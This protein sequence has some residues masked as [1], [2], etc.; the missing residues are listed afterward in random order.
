MYI[1]KKWHIIAKHW[2][3]IASTAHTQICYW[4]KEK[5]YA[6]YLRTLSNNFFH[7][8]TTKRRRIRA[9]VHLNADGAEESLGS[10]A[11]KSPSKFYSSYP[12]CFPRFPSSPAVIL[13]TSISIT[14][15]IASELERNAG[16]GRKGK[17]LS[18]YIHPHCPQN[19]Y[20]C[21]PFLSA[22]RYAETC[23]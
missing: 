13:F 1:F 12:T 3:I 17:S 14:I 10:K 21:H 19:C 23:S 16:V 6:T 8:S 22:L 2:E 11:S 7:S 18:L 15:N 9:L 4:R 20:Q 5:I